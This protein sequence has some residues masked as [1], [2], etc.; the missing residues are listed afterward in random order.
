MRGLEDAGDVVVRGEALHHVPRGP[1]V[2]G[3][4]DAGPLTGVH[5]V[6][7]AA[8]LL[9]AH[10]PRKTSNTRTNS[11]T[12]SVLC[13]FCSDKAVCPWGQN[14]PCPAPT[15]WPLRTRRTRVS[16]PARRRAA[17]QSTN[18][19]RLGSSFCGIKERCFRAP[20]VASRSRTP[21]KLQFVSRVLTYCSTVSSTRR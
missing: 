1:A 18:N 2:L 14:P 9:G 4:H 16:R 7:V 6:P 11:L 10:R 19:S 17:R 3:R 5:H 21:A 12:Q 8:L 20:W 13:V 15:T